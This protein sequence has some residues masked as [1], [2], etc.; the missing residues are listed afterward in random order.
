MKINSAHA[1]AVFDALCQVG[2]ERATKLYEY[3]K[4]HVLNTSDDD[5]DSQH[6]MYDSFCVSIGADGILKMTKFTTVE[7]PYFYEMLEPAV[8]HYGIKVEAADVQTFNL[9]YPL[10]F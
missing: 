3:S 9:M 5:R 2:E 10:W 4:A 6:S 8:Y 7:I 1:S